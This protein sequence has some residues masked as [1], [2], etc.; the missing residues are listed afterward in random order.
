MFCIAVSAI[1]W[2]FMHDYFA[3]TLGHPHATLGYFVLMGADILNLCI[4]FNL[5]LLHTV[6]VYPFERKFRHEKDLNSIYICSRTQQAKH[7]RQ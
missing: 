5:D 6:S 1:L 3:R 7:A 4:N 2:I